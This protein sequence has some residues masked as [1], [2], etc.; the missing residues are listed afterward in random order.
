M[1][2]IQTRLMEEIEMKIEKP[3][4]QMIEGQMITNGKDTRSMIET[5]L[6]QKTIGIKMPHHIMEEAF[7]LNNTTQE[8]KD[9]KM[10]DL[11]EVTEVTEDK[12]TTGVVATE[13]AFTPTIIRVT[14]IGLI[15]SKMITIAI[16][17]L[18]T[19]S[20]AV[21]EEVIEV[22]EGQGKIRGKIDFKGLVSLHMKVIEVDGEEET[23]MIDEFYN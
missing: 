19:N 2:I 8:M 13:E 5:D 16:D 15:I 12:V 3:V 20:E 17:H 7:H 10:L 21:E 11:I 22:E 9:Q 23:I 18:H 6:K 14:I 1:D 4:F